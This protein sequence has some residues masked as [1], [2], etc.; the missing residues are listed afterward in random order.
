MKRHSANVI[1]AVGI[2]LAFW[3]NALAWS[4]SKNYGLMLVLSLVVGL[5][6]FLDGQIARRTSCITSIGISLD[7]F[8]DK[9]FVCPLFVLFLA[10]LW[11]SQSELSTLIKGM[12]SILIIVETGL[13]T[14]SL[15]G[16]FKGWDI[17][18]NK[19]GKRKM[20][21]YFGFLSFVFLMKAKGD[22]RGIQELFYADV[23][24]AVILFFAAVLAIL[25]LEGY[26]SRY[27][28]PNLPV[29]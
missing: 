8:R 23:V 12:I 11:H 19:Y 3:V 18:P 13:I 17:S 16:F 9:V 20:W 22:A 4:D 7:K 5:T 6:D 1:T 10:E 21:F 28:R 29:K 14:A 2:V 25:S 15:V 26:I 27:T 24:T